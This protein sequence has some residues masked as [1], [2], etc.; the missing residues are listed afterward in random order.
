MKRDMDIRKFVIVLALPLAIALVASNLGC[1]PAVPAMP[2]YTNDVRP[3]LM[4][5]CVRCHG[6]NEMLNPTPD[7]PGARN[8]PTI[9]YLQRYEDA[10]DC[11]VV[12]TCQHGAGYCG[13][14]M[15]GSTESLIASRIKLPAGETGAMPPPPADRLNDWEMEVLTRWSSATPAP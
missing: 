2:T 4:A 14:V 5:H 7:V 15:Q 8:V 12:A 3:I 1:S 9:C 11:T 10:G 13:T 6:A